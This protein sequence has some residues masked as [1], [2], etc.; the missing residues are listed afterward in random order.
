MGSPRTRGRL[1]AAAVGKPADF[2]GSLAEVAS[3]VS[4]RSS[5][6][7]VLQ[8]VVDEAKVLVRCRKSF[9][10]LFD[11]TEERPRMGASVVVVRG[12]RDQ[13]PEEWWQSCVDD[14]G[15]QVSDSGLPMLVED[16]R[17]NAALVCV[18]IRAHDRSIGL[19]SAI[20]SRTRSFT[21]EQITLLAV[22]G[23]FAG[24]AIENARL[25]AQSEYALL[26]GERNRI[27]KEMHDGLAQSL[28]SASLALEVCKR[29]SRAHPDEVEEKLGETQQ[30]LSESL[31]ELRRYIFDLRPVSL[32]RLGLAGA[33]RSK[34][35]E[36]VRS[37]RLT[38][39][40]VVTGKE[41]SLSPSV[42]ACLYRITQEAVANAVKHAHAASVI[43]T[44]TY[45]KDT[46]ELLIEDDG[47]GFDVAEAAARAESGRSLGLRSMR[48]RV[49]A[50][51]GRFRIYSAQ[52]GGTNVWVTVPC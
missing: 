22:L 24:V 30:L 12:S 14:I 1:L 32:E 41:R 44:L 6:G 52:R 8:R 15:P 48:D 27:A 16:A 29:R 50:E 26:A 39:E 33:I 47:D 18:P 45:A 13:Y 4:S 5:I 9:L 38:G 35:E 21:E 40:L 20:N 31:T 49:A 51:A 46:V 37:G 28:F 43:V 2:V 17:H 36:V 19:L 42:E 34:I 7:E 23:A 10:L 3:V 25:R 11:E